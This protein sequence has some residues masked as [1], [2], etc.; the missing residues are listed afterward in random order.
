[1][2]F[3]FLIAAYFLTGNLDWV[4][5]E[6]TFNAGAGLV[7]S[8]PKDIEDRN[9]T[10]VEQ[11][12]AAFERDWFSRYTI[13]LQANNFL[14]CNKRQI[15]HSQLRNGP[16]PNQKRQ[17]DKGPAPLRNHHKVDG[18]TSDKTRHRDSRLSKMNRQGSANGLVPV[19]DSYQERSQVKT[20]HFD[21]RQVEIKG[22][23]DN[24]VDLPSQSAESS[25]SREIA[26]GFV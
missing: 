22:N 23:H 13:P 3:L 14:V 16:V 6:F 19:M 4:G 26:N 18:Q 21:N 20:S 11:L 8:K 10:V 5:D 24:P 9:F 7:I 2:S 1:M 17:H 12:R 15:K 25:G